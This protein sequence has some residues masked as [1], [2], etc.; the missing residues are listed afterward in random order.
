M[1]TV[2]EYRL[3]FIFHQMSQIKKPLCQVWLSI[4][5]KKHPEF[6]VFDNPWYFP[7]VE[8]YR[9]LLESEGFRVEYMKI[10]PRPTPMDDVGNWLDIFANGVSKH[11]SKTQFETFKKECRE[12]L[13]E[14]IYSEEEGWMLD[15]KRLRVR[16]VKI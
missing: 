2:D 14:T 7:S 4:R 10:I 3:F 12:I 6:G 8:E 1:C 5:G 15:Y 9:T 11:L 16:A 13:K